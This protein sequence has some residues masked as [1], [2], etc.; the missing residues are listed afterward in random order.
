MC[1]AEKLI[2]ENG[3]LQTKNSY[4]VLPTTTTFPNKL[5]LRELANAGEELAGVTGQC[6]VQGSQPVNYEQTRKKELF[7]I[8][9]GLQF[10]LNEGNVVLCV[11]Q[12]TIPPSL[13]FP[14]PAF[15]RSHFPSP[16]CF[17]PLFQTKP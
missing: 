1:Q 13:T 2:M 11:C 5:E 8:C 6:V 3:W 4:E 10:I 17:V 9:F 7:F 15:F 12:F 16:L 14:F